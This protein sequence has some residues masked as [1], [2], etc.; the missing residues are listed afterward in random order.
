M[1]EDEISLGYWAEREGVDT[2]LF[3]LKE[4]LH[5]RK[6]QRRLGRRQSPER[7]EKSQVRSWKSSK[8]E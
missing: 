4:H 8:R 5:L 7:K 1:E 3:F 6:E 2:A